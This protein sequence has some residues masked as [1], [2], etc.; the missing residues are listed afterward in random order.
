MFKK[1]IIISGVTSGGK[2][3]ISSQIAQQLNTR[4]ILGDSLQ[5]Y[6]NWPISSGWYEKS[7]KYI[8]QGILDASNGKISSQRYKELVVEQIEK[9]DN[10]LIEG[11][12]SFYLRYLLESGHT[13]FTEE[14]MQEADKKAQE[15]LNKSQKKWQ[16]LQQYCPS[17]D[18]SIN[19]NDNYRFQKGIEVCSFNRRQTFLAFTYKL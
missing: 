8:L 14:Q 4:I 6:K 11:G 19:D 13:Y 15:L 7:D 16:V 17:Y 9:Q 18:N 5:M 3:Q 12:C 1:L 10:P 2:S